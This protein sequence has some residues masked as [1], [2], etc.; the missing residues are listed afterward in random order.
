MGSEMCIR[1]SQEQCSAPSLAASDVLETAFL[2]P[3]KIKRHVFDI[4][5]DFL[6]SGAW[7]CLLGAW[8]CLLGAWTCLL[9]AWTIIVI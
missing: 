2:L 5:F 4:F 8:I 6:G 9:G 1:D 7:N 3:K